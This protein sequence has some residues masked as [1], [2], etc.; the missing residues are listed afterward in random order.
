M[1]EL[2]YFIAGCCF[3]ISLFIFGM[4]FQKEFIK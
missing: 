3:G 4:I 2:A 1:I